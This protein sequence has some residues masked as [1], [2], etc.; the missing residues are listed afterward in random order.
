MKSLKRIITKSSVQLLLFILISEYTGI[1]QQK[2]DTIFYVKSGNYILN[3][4]Y[5]MQKK[6]EITGSITS[7]SSQDFNRG[8]IQNPLQLIQGKIAGLSV[9]KPGGDP[10]G[11]FDVRLRGLTTINS[12]LMPLIVVD[13]ITD[14]S[15]TNVDPDDIESITVLKDAS[16]AA[17]YGTR[18]SNGVIMITTKRGL[19][20][21]PVVSY[22][23]YA[24]AEKVA[25]NNQSMSISQWRAFSQETGYGTDFGS[26][27]DC[28]KEIEQTALSQVHN[29]SMSGG[30]NS[31]SYR[32]AIN[33]RTGN[34]AQINTGY[35]QLN[36]RINITQKAFKDKFTL[37]LNMSASERESQLGFAEAFRYATIYN[38]TA[39]VKS[40]DPE[41]VQYDGYFQ[42]ELWMNYN[43]VQIT[44]EDKNESKD[45]I[46]NLSLKG[47]Y[48]I[49]HG[50]NIDALYAVQNGGKLGGQYYN[51][52]ELWGGMTLNGFASRGE[53]N[54]HN[55]LLE[56]SA[57]YNAEINSSLNIS[58]VGGYTSQ[59]Y[60]NEGFTAEGG[61]F[62]TD[63]FS[64]DNLA[65]SL[66][67]K[68]GKAGVLSYKNNNR[69]AAYF[70]RIS[71][72]LNDWFYLTGSARY[73]G[74]SRF[75][76]NNKWGLFPAIS[77]GMFLAKNL[78]FVDML[79]IRAGYGITGNQ[80][81]ESYMSLY[82]IT[83]HKFQQQYPNG[84]YYQNYPLYYFNGSYY[85]GIVTDL[86]ANPD[87]K[88]EQK[89]E[90]NFGIDFSLLKS[91]FSGS[92]DFYTQKS[93]DLLYEYN[94]LPMPPNIA[95]SV[96][97][98]SGEIKSH[99][100]EI[101]LSYN[102]ITSSDVTDDVSFTFS[103]NSEN[104]LVS[105]ST[106]FNGTEFPYSPQYL[107]YLGSPSWCCM[108][109]ISSAE[110]QPVGQISAYV[111]NG[112]M[113]DG[114][115][116]LADKNDDGYTDDR[117]RI[118]AGNGLPKYIIGLGN[119]LTFKNFDFSIF[120][121]G[122]LGHSLINSF[123][124][125]Y[126]SVN[127]MYYYNVPETTVEMKNS[128]GEYYRGNSGAVTTRNVENASFISLDNFS[129]GYSFK[130]KDNSRFSKIRI[131]IAG[132]NL[133]YITKYT[134]SDPSPRYV[135]H[136]V[137]EGSYNSPLVP[138]VDRLVSWPR[139]RSVTIGANVVF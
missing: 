77:G 113:E 92:V 75:G 7:V 13:G 17:I 99:G 81:D 84:V 123:R 70:G 118:V 8:Y 27:T 110:G 137:N 139:T 3:T 57:R 114:Y 74:A 121:R 100:M 22:N 78:R 33:Y 23:V 96:W 20:G 49:I 11:V 34:G 50:L 104:T 87:L 25:K 18:A 44:E 9:N 21:K 35:N 85:P 46:L 103:H 89:A 43:P 128:S 71:L 76:S 73:E 116:S 4:G 6:K 53:D 68:N 112:I 129:L 48:E 36:G 45:R 62:I 120:F 90:F 69:L 88:W 101:T 109:L 80:P 39:P 135:D 64:F 5:G 138:G 28:F 67:I 93:S 97:L 55:N 127:D 102:V 14:A 95:S 91:K 65:A 122:V 63:D 125:Q 19:A 111:Y 1:S 41:F 117:D 130:Q 42:K 24:T 134:G 131:Y 37:D 115:Q 16:S 94:W 52:H 98:N 119:N 66:D 86:N 107:G 108:P 132:N 47:T 51:K 124:A 15:I 79:K 12:G 2:S 61:N 54:S 105:L 30:T 126:E 58:A 29:I 60:T 136:A 32:A 72:N 82:T 133:F 106:A 26:S 38:P 56:I 83:Q 59:D 31:T 10:N 40:D